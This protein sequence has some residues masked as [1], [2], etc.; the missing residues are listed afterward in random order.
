MYLF[1]S[2]L[3]LIFLHLKI[4]KAFLG[5]QQV[6]TQFDAEPFDNTELTH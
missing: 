1:F 6:N 3:V 5:S 2:S 4:C